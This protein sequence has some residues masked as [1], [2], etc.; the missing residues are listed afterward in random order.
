MA[1][2]KWDTQQ[3]FYCYADCS[4]A[5]VLRVS[6]N[7]VVMLSVIMLTEVMLSSIIRCMFRVCYYADIVNLS[8]GS[9]S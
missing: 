8:Q 5:G 7:S 4:L 9:I 2:L 3:H 1:R 6:T